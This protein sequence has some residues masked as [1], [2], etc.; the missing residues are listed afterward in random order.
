MKW[1]LKFT[2]VIAVTVEQ[3]PNSTT[4]STLL[5]LTAFVP[6]KDLVNVCRKI[7]QDARGN[8]S[9]I[10]AVCLSEMK[11]AM[12]GLMSSN[13]IERQ[14]G[15]A[16]TLLDQC[17]KFHQFVTADGSFVVSPRQ[18]GTLAMKRSSELGQPLVRFVPVQY[19]DE[20]CERAVAPGGNCEMEYKSALEDELGIRGLTTPLCEELRAQRE[21]VG[22][23]PVDSAHSFCML[24]K[25]RVES[26]VGEDVPVDT[27]EPAPQSTTPV[28]PVVEDQELEPTERVDGNIVSGARNAD[29]RAKEHYVLQ[30]VGESE[31][32]G[33]H[34]TSDIAAESPFA[35]SAKAKG[36]SMWRMR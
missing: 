36:R 15:M 28:K 20:A 11:A 2:A 29:E 35:D 31:F 27:R 22:G 16:S 6:D 4:T 9:S 5:P 8:P 30:P 26:V 32:G 12:D 17:D 19:I 3:I 21:R 14:P 1:W 7:I 13:V 25:T 18:C 34:W 33:R 10:Q 24:R 23:G